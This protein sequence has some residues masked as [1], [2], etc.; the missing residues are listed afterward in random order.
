M[1]GIAQMKLRVIDA[2]SVYHQLLAATDAAERETL[3]RAELLE[4]FAGM[5]RV[6][7]EMDLLQAARQWN[8]YLPE[9]FA[10]DARPAIEALIS[11]L[12][13]DDAWRRAAEG[14]ERGLAAFA[15]LERPRGGYDGIS[16]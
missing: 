6:F 5:V 9:D 13:Q 14:F 15:P 8:V 3:Y 10:S 12:A 11:Q 7:G 4:P 16:D 1:R 2:E